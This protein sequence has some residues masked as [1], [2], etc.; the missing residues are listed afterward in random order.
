MMDAIR[1]W[2]FERNRWK[3]CPHSRLRPIYGDEIIFGTPDWNRLQCRDCGNWL[4]GPVSLAALRR[5]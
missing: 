5:A 1:N 4:R 3:T 2:W